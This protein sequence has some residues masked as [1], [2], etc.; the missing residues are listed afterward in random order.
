[1]KNVPI[2]LLLTGLAGCATPSKVV[3]TFRA[4]DPAAAPF[5]SVLVVGIAGSGNSRRSF[6]DA[7]VAELGAGTM[8]SYR[9][10]SRIENID[11]DTVAAAARAN[12]ADAVLV[13]RI[14]DAQTQAKVQGARTDVQAQRKD[15][16]MV[17]F[18]RYDYVATTD[19]ESIKMLTTVVLASDLYRVSDERRV[20]AMESTAFERE[21]VRDIVDDLSGAIAGQLRRRGLVR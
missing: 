18:F 12:G 13:T 2:L 14:K 5:E 6:E 17:D 10:I 3:E 8:V 16:R 9:D 1:M 21:T 11:R 20:Y 15:D 4:D 19:P 7:L